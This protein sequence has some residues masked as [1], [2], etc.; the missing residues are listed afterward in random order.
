MLVKVTRQKWGTTLEDIC[1]TENVSRTGVYFL[2]SQNYDIG[3]QVKIVMPHKEGD[4]SIP[5]PAR[6]VR[7]DLAKGSFQRGVALHLGEG[8][9]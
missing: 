9:S 2:T 6:V 7:Q 8:K 1:Q 3:E 4:V 5:V